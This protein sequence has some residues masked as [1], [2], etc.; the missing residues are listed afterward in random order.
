[1]LSGERV[2]GRWATQV[3]LTEWPLMYRDRTKE[4]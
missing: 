4:K 3:G 1:M 2:K